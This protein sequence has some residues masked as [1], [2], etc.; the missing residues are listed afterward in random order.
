MFIVE[1]G[2][3]FQQGNIYQLNIFV[4]PIIRSKKTALKVFAFPLHFKAMSSIE[5][6]IALLKKTIIGDI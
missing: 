6:V 2:N 4:F 1:M 5:Y 3:N